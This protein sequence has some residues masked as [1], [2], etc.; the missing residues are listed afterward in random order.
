MYNDYLKIYKCINSST[1]IAQI[2]ACKKLCDLFKAKW[3]GDETYILY[4]EKLILI[5]SYKK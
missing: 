5:L 2:Q 3:S 1:T 4:Y